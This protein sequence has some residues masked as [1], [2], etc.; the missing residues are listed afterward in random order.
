M[1]HA[2]HD[3]RHAGLGHRQDRRTPSSPRQQCHRGSRSSDRRHPRRG[4][5]AEGAPGPTTAT[6]RHAAGRGRAARLARRPQPPSG[7]R[8]RPGRRRHRHLHRLDRRTTRLLSP[9]RPRRQ[10]AAGR[11]TTRPQLRRRRRHHRQDPL[12][13][14]PRRGAGDS[15][16]RPHAAPNSGRRASAVI[17]SPARRRASR[18][19]Q[20]RSPRT[21]SP[22][23]RPDPIGYGAC[24]LREGVGI[25][26]HQHVGGVAQDIGYSSQL[27]DVVSPVHHVGRRRMSKPVRREAGQSRLLDEELEGPIEAAGHAPAGRSGWR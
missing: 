25:D 19:V 15:R 13:P 21:C 16:A 17:S 20:T 24:A 4:C 14:A 9:T 23:P 3:A 7:P 5:T 27:A 18:R 26:L 1:R 11:R 6:R 8:P 22:G 10:D 12:V 2:S